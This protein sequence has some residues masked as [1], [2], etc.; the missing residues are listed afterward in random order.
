MR[1]LNLSYF[2]ATLSSL[3]PPSRVSV[4]AFVARCSRGEK[5]LPS[6]QATELLLMVLIR[7]CS[8]LPTESINVLRVRE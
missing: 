5:A 4:V 3:Q 2:A 6:A 7:S 8:H 1:G